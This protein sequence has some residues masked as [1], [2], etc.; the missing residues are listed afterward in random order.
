M[1]LPL[2]SS[3]GFLKVRGPER[4]ETKCFGTTMKKEWK[5]GEHEDVAEEG[6]FENIF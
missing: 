2:A 1:E 5:S 3:Q 4:R 6:H